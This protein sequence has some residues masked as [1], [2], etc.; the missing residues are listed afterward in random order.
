MPSRVL[1]APPN[2]IYG[3]ESVSLMGLSGERSAAEEL[4]HNS[5]L[6]D[7]HN[8]LPWEARE[9]VGYD[10]DRMD[11]SLP[12]AST[13]TDLPRLRRG[14][15]GGQFWSVWVPSSWEGGRAVV[16]TL[17]Q[18]DFVYAMLARY[19]DQLGI[20]TSADEVVG[21]FR[22]GRI[23]CLLGAEGGHSINSSMGALR[24]LYRLGVRY[25]TLT[26][27]DNTPWADSATDSPRSGG[28]SP[29]GKQVVRE[30]QRLGMLVDLSHVAATTMQDALDVSRA[31]VIFSHSSARALC[32]HPRNVP[33]DILGQLKGNGGVCMVTFVPQFVSVSCRQWALRSEA[34]LYA[35]GVDLS[36]FGLVKAALDEWSQTDPRPQAVLADVVAHL[37][38]V[39]EVAGLEHVGIGGDFDGSPYMPRGLSDV[40]G[41]PSLFAAL[42][43]SGWS[44]SDCI[45]LAGGNILRVLRSAERVAEE[46]SA[47]ESPSLATIDELD[48]GPAQPV[49]G[50]S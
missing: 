28:L 8:D 9:Q 24:A 11:L 36:D 12:V 22:A 47:S 5:P 29:F 50:D 7:G 37:N 15:V 46:L 40:T 27:N 38:H 13:D 39:R 32:D 16:G 35:R 20:A 43:E 45:A 42:L 6:I 17:E 48:A 4:L 31:P 18:I 49:L 25:M 21:Q 19:P 3:G 30:M 14:G 10:L 44:Q 41:Y 2:L 23:A 33:D 26:H 34:E 1:T